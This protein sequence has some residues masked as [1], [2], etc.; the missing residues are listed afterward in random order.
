MRGECILVLA[1]GARVL[2]RSLRPDDR[3][4]LAERYEQLS[5]ESRHLRFFFAPEHLSVQQL[6]ELLDV[7]GV[8]R[9]ALVA[10]MIDEPGAPGVGLARYARTPDDPASAEAAVTVLDSHRHR[11][12]GTMLLL[13]L[14]EEAVE[15]GITRLGASV[16][17]ENEELLAALRGRG[18]DITPAEPGIALVRMDLDRLRS[19]RVAAGQ[20]DCGDV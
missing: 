13:A 9:C 12:L 20:P 3:A 19:G 4:E 8:D 7:D 17:W 14:A 18:A 15:H 6:D 10:R 16:L 2:V 11:G 1:D 5:P